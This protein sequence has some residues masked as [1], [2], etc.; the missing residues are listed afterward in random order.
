MTQ[1]TTAPCARC[2][3]CEGTEL[4][5]NRTWMP[6]YLA[7]SLAPFLPWLDR[8]VVVVCADCG[9]VQQLVGEK[10]RRRVKARWSRLNDSAR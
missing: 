4:Y 9:Y 2:P 1:S 6:H 7:T 3:H 8:W 10:Y 5:V